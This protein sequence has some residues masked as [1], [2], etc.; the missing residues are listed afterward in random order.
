[1]RRKDTLCEI[2]GRAVSIFGTIDVPWWPVD[3]LEAVTLLARMQEG[4]A[5]SVVFWSHQRRE[6]V[7]GSFAVQRELNV[8]RE[9]DPY[10]A[11][12]VYSCRGGIVV[13]SLV[14]NHEE[15]ARAYRTMLSQPQVREQSLL[16]VTCLRSETPF[17]KMNTIMEGDII[18]YVNDTPVRT[19]DDYRRA[20]EAWHAGTV[21]YMVLQLLDGN[22]ATASRAEVEKAEHITRRDTELDEL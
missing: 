8:Y 14:A 22:I 2:D 20:W 13:Q 16:V 19:V 12:P 9:I 7:R 21:P 3:A 11:P 17:S 5:L 18:N 4:D 15:L 6:L 1:M 10:D